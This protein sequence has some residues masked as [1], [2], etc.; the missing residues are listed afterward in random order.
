MII[1]QI[2]RVLASEDD[3]R[4]WTISSCSINWKY[5]SGSRYSRSGIGSFLL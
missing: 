3:S 4:A 1:A 5:A 2:A